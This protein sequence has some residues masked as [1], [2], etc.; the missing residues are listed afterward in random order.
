MQQVMED[1]GNWI[2]G[3]PTALLGLYQGI[4]LIWNTGANIHRILILAE[5]NDARTYRLEGESMAAPAR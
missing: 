2:V 4:K 3:I 1:W 5:R